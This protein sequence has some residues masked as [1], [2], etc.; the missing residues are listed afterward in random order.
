MRARLVSV[1]ASQCI[2]EKQKAT[3][4]VAFLSKCLSHKDLIW[5]RF[6]DSNPGPADYDSV[7]LTG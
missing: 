1:L 5:W 7:A 3:A 6:R 4:R 2:T